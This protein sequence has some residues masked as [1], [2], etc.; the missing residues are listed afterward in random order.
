ME[1]FLLAAKVYYIL[2]IPVLTEYQLSHLLQTQSSHAPN[3][4][5]R[6]YRWHRP[7]PGSVHPSCSGKVQRKLLWFAQ[8]PVGCV[9]NR[10]SRASPEW[11]GYRSRRSWVDWL[12]CELSEDRNC[13]LRWHLLKN[14]WWCYLTEKENTTVRYHKSE[15]YDRFGPPLE[16]TVLLFGRIGARCTNRFNGTAFVIVWGRYSVPYRL[17]R[18]LVPVRE[19]GC[20]EISLVDSNNKTPPTD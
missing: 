14:F 13:F 12:R 11:N 15:R 17:R 3:R 19:P 8:N 7:C 5:C 4:E 16:A 9:G 6:R 1:R 10:Y 2:I 20:P 18:W